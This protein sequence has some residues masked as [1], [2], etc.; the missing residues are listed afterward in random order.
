MTCPSIVQ[1]LEHDERR[2]IEPPY[3]LQHDVRRQVRPLVHLGRHRRYDERGAEKVPRVVLQHQYRTG[4]SLL[5]SEER[6]QVRPVDIAP[7]IDPVGAKAFALLC[8]HH[9]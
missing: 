9:H 7:L 5:R 4:P 8:L 3:L 1:L 2:S 6:V